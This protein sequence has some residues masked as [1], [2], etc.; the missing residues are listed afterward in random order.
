MNA[1]IGNWLVIHGRTLD[2]PVREGVIV[3]VAHPDGSPPYLVRWLDDDRLSLVFP[4]A[5]ALVQRTAPHGR[6]GSAARQ[7]S[8]AGGRRG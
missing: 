5:D 8:S 3:D 1:A 7:V 4:G 6:V 2:D